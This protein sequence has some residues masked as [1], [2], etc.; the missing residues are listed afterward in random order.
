MP[1]LQPLPYKGT[2]FHRFIFVLYKQVKKLNLAEYQVKE[3]EGMETRTFST[4][5]FYKQNQE[6]ITPAGIGFFQTKYDDSVRDVFHNKLSELFQW[7]LKTIFLMY[8]FE[9]FID[10]KQPIFEYDF[11]EAYLKYQKLFPKKQPFNLY[12]DRYADPKDVN[13]RFLERRLAKTHPF[14]GPDAPLKFPSA[15]TLDDKYPS[16]LKT[17]IR[18][19]RLRRGRINDTE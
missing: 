2:G 6:L 9:Y 4:Y 11:P 16:W 8:N 7:N 19:E 15:H 14:N 3:S 17:E 18:K 1:Y 13:K 5:E 10:K 12:L